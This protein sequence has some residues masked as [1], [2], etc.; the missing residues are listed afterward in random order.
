MSRKI[1]V[2]LIGSQFISTLHAE[3]LKT[4]SDAE[5]LAVTS[6]T[7]GHAQEFAKKFDIPN[8]FTDINDLLAIDDIDMVVIGAPNHVH[9]ELTLAAAKAGKHIVI[10]KPFCLN[11]QE[12]D[13]MIDAC[14]TAN[15]KL[16]YAEVLCFTPK[17][18]RMKELLDEG[19]LGD[20]IF[21]KQSEQH[22]G[23]HSAHFWDMERAGGGATM[24]L[25]CHAIEFFR[26]MLGNP[27]IK[28]VYAQMGTYVHMDKTEGDDHAVIL[29]EFENGVTAMAEESWTNLGGMDDKAEVHGTEGHAHADLLKGNSILTY[30][31]KGVGYA[32]EKAGDTKGWSFTMFEELWNYGFPQQ[33]AHF[34][35]CVKNDKQPITTGEDGKAV[36]EAIFA[37]YESAGTGKKVMLP[38]ET[39]VDKPYKLWKKR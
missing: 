6:P 24:D 28:S 12:A 30:S 8:H 29:I 5:I 3:A 21:I 11:L 38:F 32:V 1:G 33:F 19:A 16:M 4:V 2:G 36:L 10:E 18:V 31:K 15:V 39:T 22:D 26:W 27:K 35:D 17:Y 9:C 25:G 34:V 7:P 14:K 20:P 23:P 37:A 13:L